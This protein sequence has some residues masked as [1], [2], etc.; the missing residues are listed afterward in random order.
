MPFGGLY[1]TGGLTPKFLDRIRDPDG[2]FM[3]AY[4]DKGRVVQGPPRGEEGERVC[5]STRPQ[6]GLSYGRGHPDPY[7]RDE[8]SGRWRVGGCPLPLMQQGFPPCER[9][10]PPSLPP[11]PRAGSYA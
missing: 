5:P 7:P 3:R 6:G 11:P 2:P 4:F 8:R 9:G 10:E 1:L